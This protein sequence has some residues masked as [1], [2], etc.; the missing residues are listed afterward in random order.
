MESADFSLET[1]GASLFA[2]VVIVLLI[3]LLIY[4]TTQ[5]ILLPLVIG[6]IGEGVLAVLYFVK[7][8]HVRRLNPENTESFQYVQSLQ[9]FYE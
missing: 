3:G 4:H 6:V 2:L 8:K 1:A 7:Q 9:Q 5:N